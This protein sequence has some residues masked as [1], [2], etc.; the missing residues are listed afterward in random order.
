MTE[1]L[2]DVEGATHLALDRGGRFRGWYAFKTFLKAESIP[3]NYKD[4]TYRFNFFDFNYRFVMPAKIEF[5]GKMIS[6]SK[7]ERHLG[8][9]RFPRDDQGNFSAPIQLKPKELSVDLTKEEAEK[10]LAR[11]TPLV[12][13]AYKIPQFGFHFIDMNEIVVQD[14]ASITNSTFASEIKAEHT[15]LFNEKL[16]EIMAKITSLPNY[17]LILEN[18][19]GK[20]L[21]D[22]NEVATMTDQI[23][24][25]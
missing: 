20:C 19:L 5:D 1:E 7:W 9:F 14:I 25:A 16:N 24:H 13:E 23:I 21:R 8:I 4:L 22:L 17:L 15:R 10:I 2:V 11:K 3:L 12:F 6:Y 18:T